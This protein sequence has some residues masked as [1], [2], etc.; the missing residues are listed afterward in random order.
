M[1]EFR[2]DGIEVMLAEVHEPVK[3]MAHHS[4]L[5]EKIGENHIYPTVDV[6]VQLF[7]RDGKIGGYE[8]NSE[9]Q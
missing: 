2:K 1:E 9:Q 4:G 7:L 5:M 6:A 8:M 3:Q